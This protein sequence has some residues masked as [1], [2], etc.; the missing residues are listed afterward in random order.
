MVF[1]LSRG[2]CRRRRGGDD[3]TRL[4]SVAT[5]VLHP[6]FIQR[7]AQGPFVYLVNSDSTNQTVTMRPVTLE[8]SDARAGTSAVKG[9]EPGEVVA[10]D[11]FNRLQEGAKVME[12]KA[13]APGGKPAEGG[14]KPRGGA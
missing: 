14:H 9:I 12:R 10:G 2:R 7:N 5:E 1:R 11:N 8:A 3:N 4:L 6:L 13:G